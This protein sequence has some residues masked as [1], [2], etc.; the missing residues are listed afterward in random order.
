MANTLSQNLETANLQDK[1][2]DLFSSDDLK[3]F[4][5]LVK[6]KDDFSEMLKGFD[7]Q[8]TIDTMKKA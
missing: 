2:A 5:D 7:K 8:E 6:D 1:K 4:T 3:A